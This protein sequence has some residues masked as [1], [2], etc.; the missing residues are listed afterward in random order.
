MPERP[1]LDIP[2]VLV[3][4]YLGIFKRFSVDAIRSHATTLMQLV[5][6]SNWVISQP[7][8]LPSHKHNYGDATILSATK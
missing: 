1:S 3:F 4:E 5:Y 2:I 7:Y 8:M 6:Q